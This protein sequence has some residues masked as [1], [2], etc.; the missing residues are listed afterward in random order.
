MSATPIGTAI[1]LATAVS[2]RLGGRFAASVVVR[3]PRARRPVAEQDERTMDAARRSTLR[4][5]GI[6]RHGTDVR[7]YEWGTGDTTIALAHGWHGRASQ[8]ATL[9]RELT[10]DGHRVVA[11]DA[12]GHGESEGSR[13]YLVDWIDVLRGLDERHDGFH[14]VVG[15][16][17]GGAST[18]AAVAN[19]VRAHR[20]VTA[21]AP[22]GTDRMFEHFQRVLGYSDRSADAARRAFVDLWFDGD[23]AGFDR[24]SPHRTPL[25]AE[26]DV[27]AF[28]DETDAVVPFGE[29][30]R[31]QNA[32]PHAFPVVTNG[33]GHSAILRAEIF[34]D[35]VLGFLARPVDAES[36]VS[37]RS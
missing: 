26:V 14:A 20:V 6:H 16:S 22:A 24:L 30:A 15:H 12:P 10:A 2:P 32:N 13:S 37:R 3:T 23:A 8:F 18:L 34:L 31:V 35:G 21:S 33:I 17:F 25:P 11:F 5:P 9:V 36:P 28:H 7:V 1:D 29:L 4:I 19:G 27:L